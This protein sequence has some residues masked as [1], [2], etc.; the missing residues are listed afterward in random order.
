MF[1]V[2]VEY[3]GV[4]PFITLCGGDA[5]QFFLQLFTYM[6]YMCNLIGQIRQR[7]RTHKV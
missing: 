1:V 5:K 2:V 6:Q 3:T 7:V 4:S